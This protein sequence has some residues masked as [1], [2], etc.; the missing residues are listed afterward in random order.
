MPISVSETGHAR[1]GYEAARGTVWGAKQRA[2]RYTVDGARLGC[3]SNLNMISSLRV[4]GYRGFETFEMNGLGRINLLVGANN[5]GKTSVLE[6]IF[7]LCS[8]GDPSALWELLS[9]RGERIPPVLTDASETPAV[10]SRVELDA[11]HVFHGHD[12][13]PGATVRIQS[14]NQGTERW[15]EYTVIEDASR[16]QPVLFSGVHDDWLV[17]RLAI[18]VKGD[19]KPAVGLIPLSQEGGMYLSPL[20]V[21][22]RRKR[23]RVDEAPATQFISTDSFAGNQ[24]LV[25]WNKIVLTPSEGLVLRALQFLDPDIERIASQSTNGEQYLSRARGGF[26]VKRRGLKQPVPIGSMGDGMWRMLAMAIAITQCRGGVL[27]VDEIDTGLHYTVMSQ[28]WRLIFNAAKDLDVQV[29][30]TTHSYDCVYS[31]AQ[32][33]SRE[34]EVTVQ[35]IDLGKSRSVPYDHDEI[36]VAASRDIEVR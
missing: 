6:A 25:M 18:E 14:R 16:E 28:M 22:V 31:L 11:A 9:R 20:E 12:A 13:R 34:D 33:G 17:A 32:I 10:R 15:V 4:Q 2:C 30:A 7:L 1:K 26:I 21:T 27:L 8:A 23:L 35:R 36:T 29:F 3:C 5:S 19:P 24:L